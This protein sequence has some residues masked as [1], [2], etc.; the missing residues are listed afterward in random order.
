MKLS[1]NILSITMWRWGKEGKVF[2]QLDRFH[3]FQL[4]DFYNTAYPDHPIFFLIMTKRS[5]D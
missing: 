3:I 1:R 5:G 2:N 4:H